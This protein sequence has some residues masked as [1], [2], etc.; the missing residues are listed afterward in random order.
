MATLRQRSFGRKRLRRRH[1]SGKQGI[2][3][4]RKKQVCVQ[5]TQVSGRRIRARMAA[6]SSA[7][8]AVGQASEERCERVRRKWEV[9]LGVCEPR[10]CNGVAIALSNQDESRAW[11][12]ELVEEFG[13]ATAYRS[14]KGQYADCLIAET[15]NR[16][17][18]QKRSGLDESKYNQGGTISGRALIIKAKMLRA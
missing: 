4:E 16:L 14:T 18:R 13:D 11:S 12:V 6:D 10:M 7:R 2:T 15:K 1:L 3:L 5:R 17:R 8:K 9:V